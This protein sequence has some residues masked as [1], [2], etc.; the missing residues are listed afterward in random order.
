ML[1]NFNAYWKAL[2]SLRGDMKE[3]CLLCNRTFACTGDYLRHA[4][5]KGHQ[6][7]A[8]G[9]YGRRFSVH[10]VPVY[11]HESSSSEQPAAM[12]VLAPSNTTDTIDVDHTDHRVHH[13]LSQLLYNM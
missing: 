10:V 11:D 3:R 8:L 12:E 7:L 4:R 13:F 6:A 2:R 1:V 9:P 5:T